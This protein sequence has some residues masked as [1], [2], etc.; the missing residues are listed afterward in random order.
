MDCEVCGHSIVEITGI[1]FHGMNEFSGFGAHCTICWDD[2]TIKTICCT[3]V[4]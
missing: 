3:P 2:K 1:W 4:Q